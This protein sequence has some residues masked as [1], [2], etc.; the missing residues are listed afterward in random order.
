MIRAALLV[1]AVLCVSV[2][3]A[4]SDD[5]ACKAG[6]ACKPW[7]VSGKACGRGGRMNLRF[8]VDV[9]AENYNHSADN[10]FNGTNRWHVSYA[11]CPVVDQLQTFSFNYSAVWAASTFRY[12]STG[13]RTLHFTNISNTSYLRAYGMGEFGMPDQFPPNDYDSSAVLF[14]RDSECQSGISIAT[15]MVL[16][17]TMTNGKYR[18]VKGFHQG[19]QVGFSPSCDSSDKCMFGSHR[20]VGPKGRKNCGQCI[21]QPDDLIKTQTSVW[22]SYYGTDKSGRRLMSGS[23]NPLNFRQFA[24]TDA[25]NSVSGKV[26][27]SI[28]KL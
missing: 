20:C 23:D 15:F 28:S 26:G 14:Q 21:D 25:Y 5:N 9:A 10:V 19:V 3:V 17:I 22:T 8:A 16:N 6:T 1:I 12:N 13:H 2:A 4:A 11:F 24:T 27:D 18:H 7:S